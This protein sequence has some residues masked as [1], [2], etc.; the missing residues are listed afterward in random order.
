MVPQPSPFTGLQQNCK[1]TAGSVV[2][3]TG[4]CLLSADAQQWSGHGSGLQVIG[5]SLFHWN[6]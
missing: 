4:W 3:V 2:S 5:G 1:F 6:F